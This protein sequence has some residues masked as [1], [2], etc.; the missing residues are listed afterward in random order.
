[1]TN[2]D[3]RARIPS[4]TR[5]DPGEADRRLRRNAN[6]YRSSGVWLVV[7]GVIAAA[8]GGALA[9]IGSGGSWLGGV[10]DMIATV[11]VVPAVAGLALLLSA[12]VSAWAGRRRPFA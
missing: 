4:A 8:I 10:G 7:I 6:R 11:A 2:V 5:G 3:T 12:V 9:W 1:M